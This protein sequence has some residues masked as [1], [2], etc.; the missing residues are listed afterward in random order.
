[1]VAVDPAGLTVW[2]AGD[3]PRRVDRLA[4]GYWLMG[5]QLEPVLG[6]R[7]DGWQPGK[8]YRVIESWSETHWSVAVDGQH[9]PAT[10]RIRTAG[11]PYVIAV[12]NPGE[13]PV[14]G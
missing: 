1:M 13:R 11:F 10:A 3:D 14:L 5:E 9:R 8:R 4:H 6:A 12:N 7:S 2:T